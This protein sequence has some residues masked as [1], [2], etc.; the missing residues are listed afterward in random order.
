M[1]ETSVASAQ[2]ILAFIDLVI[3]IIL[4]SALFFLLLFVEPLVTVAMILIFAF[5]GGLYFLLIKQK[6]LKY[7]YIRQRTNAQKL[8]LYKEFF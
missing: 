7:G 6:M 4:L 5:V 1:H 2:F 8:K 3:E